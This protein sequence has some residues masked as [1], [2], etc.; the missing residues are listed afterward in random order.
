MK[1]LY[2]SGVM[3]ILAT[4]QSTLSQKKSPAGLVVIIDDSSSHLNSQYKFIRNI[5]VNPENIAVLCLNKE[6]EE[7]KKNSIDNGSFSEAFDKIGDLKERLLLFAQERHGLHIFL[8]M[9]MSAIDT[10]D[11]RKEGSC[12]LELMI[13]DDEMKKMMIDGSVVV[14]ITSSNEVSEVFPGEMEGLELEDG[15]LAVISVD[16]ANKKID[17]SFADDSKISIFKAPQSK[18][19]N[20]CFRAVTSLLNPIKIQKNMLQSTQICY[21]L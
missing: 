18:F 6:M 5:K 19:N 12:L 13:K 8:D 15:S 2:G 17:F 11:K 4:E 20:I 9:D 21:L 14:S 1:D 3:D 7:I 16:N 10:Q